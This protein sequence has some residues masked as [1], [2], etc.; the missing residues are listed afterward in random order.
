MPHYRRLLFVALLLMSANGAARADGG[1]GLR[2]SIPLFSLSAQAAEQHLGIH[3]PGPRAA[4]GALQGYATPPG[5]AYRVPPMMG[6]APGV[7][8]YYGWSQGG[9]SSRD[10]RLYQLVPPAASDARTMGLQF[11]YPF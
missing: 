11:A 7:S 5:N 10:P 1:I 3:V 6:Y 4:Y 2:L 8:L 9:Y